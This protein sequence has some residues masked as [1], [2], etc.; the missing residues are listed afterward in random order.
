MHVV[1]GAPNVLLGGS[2]SGNLSA[3]EAVREGAVDILCSDY[4]PAALLHALFALARETRREL[5]ELV[6]LVTLNPAR[7]VMMD[8]EV[9]SLRPGKKADLVV[10]QQLENGFPVITHAMVDGRSVLRMSYRE[11]ST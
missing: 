4:Y 3:T 6:R 11:G 10:V 2:H 5:P 8:G 9:G 7:A 1:A